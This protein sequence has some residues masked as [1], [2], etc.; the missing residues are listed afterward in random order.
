MQLLPQVRKC[1]IRNF[2]IFN[3]I[4]ITLNMRVKLLLKAIGRFAFVFIVLGS[5]I[6]CCSQAKNQNKQSE[7]YRELIKQD[8]DRNGIKTP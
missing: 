1:S 3:K 2:I 8:M 5:M 6:L 7:Y 4:L